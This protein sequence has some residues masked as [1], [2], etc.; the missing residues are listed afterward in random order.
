[1]PGSAETGSGD[2]LIWEAQGAAEIADVVRLFR[3]YE[4]SLSVDLCFQ[5]FEA[6]IAGLP[7]AYAPPRGRLFLARRDGKPVGCIAL[8]PLGESDGEMK[9]LYV[10]PAA[11]GT[12]AG[13]RL[14]DAVLS[15]ARETGY[16]RLLLDTLPEMVDAQRLYLGLGFQETQAYVHNPVPGAKFMVLHLN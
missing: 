1:M 15:A 12:G 2:V 16:R 6:E 14:V 5:D 13:R 3:E 9:R 7:G 11:R 8:R 10:R 4:T